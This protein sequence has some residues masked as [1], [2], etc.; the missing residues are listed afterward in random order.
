MTDPTPP[1]PEGLDAVPVTPEMES[2]GMK[3]WDR[4]HK[5]GERMWPTML[6]AVYR[7]MLA[8][9]PP[10]ASATAD[11]ERRLAEATGRLEGKQVVITDLESRLAAL[12]E[13]N[14]ALEALTPFARDVLAERRRQVEVEGWTPEHDDTHTDGSLAAAGAAYAYFWTA[15]ENGQPPAFDIW[16]RTWSEEWWKPGDD[17]R[18]G[19]IKGA[20]LILAEGD[21]LDRLSPPSQRSSGEVQ[22]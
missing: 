14:A 18:R 21:R 22:T 3:E 4:Q 17:P 7:A 20:A 5:A 10:L 6:A 12:T 8:A 9:A 13:R 1:M 19:L 15:A 11:L 16:P 2:A